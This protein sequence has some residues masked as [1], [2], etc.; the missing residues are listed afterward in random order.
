MP[1]RGALRRPVVYQEVEIKSVVMKGFLISKN[2]MPLLLVMS[3]GTFQNLGLQNCIIFVLCC[4]SLVR[5]IQKLLKL[6]NAFELKFVNTSTIE[7]SGC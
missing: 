5:K 1:L 2:I 6:G 4:A 3:K 7:F